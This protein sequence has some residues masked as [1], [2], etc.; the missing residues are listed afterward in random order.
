MSKREREPFVGPDG[1]WANVALGVVIPIVTI[2]IVGLF[3]SLFLKFGSGRPEQ[4]SWAEA[5]PGGILATFFLVAFGFVGLAFKAVKDM[6][7]KDRRILG[8]AVG[9]V[10]TLAVLGITLRVWAWSG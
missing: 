5:I 9:A 2:I 4:V 10:T 3:V 6:D 7:L 8:Q 1:F